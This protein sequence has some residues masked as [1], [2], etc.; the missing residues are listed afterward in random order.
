MKSQI[1]IDINILKNN[2]MLLGEN[3]EEYDF[4]II[5]MRNNCFGLGSF[6]VNTFAQNGF[7]YG[8]VTDLK[9]ALSVRKYNQELPLIV[10]SELW[11]D[12]IYD[13]INNNLVLMIGSLTYLKSLVLKNLKDDLAIHLLVDNGANWKGFANY[14]ELSEAISLINQN[15]HLVL[16]GIYTE[17]TTYGLDDEDYYHQMHNFL[18]TI[19]PIDTRELLIYA[20]EP[21][22]YHPKMAKINGIKLDLAV[23][24]L[25]QSFNDYN[26]RRVKKIAK[27]YP[28]E[29]FSDLDIQLKLSFAITAPVNGLKEVAAGTLIGR[30]YRAG[31]DTKI[32]SI[33][34]GH[35]DGVT[36]ALKVVVINDKICDCLTDSLEEM[37]VKVDDS[38]AVGDKVY[39]ISDFNNISSVLLNLKTNRYYLMSLLN[40]N[41][42]RVYY[43]DD[44]AEEINY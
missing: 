15:K 33:A 20:N 12:E 14:R 32:A 22:M 24:G 6:L 1:E 38:I 28:G 2:I 26:W 11:E 35:K 44:Q 34:I 21:L 17:F 5:D 40:N 19:E 30:N 9:E 43:Q 23:F 10:S 25:P 7:T 31:E 42:P 13:A 3:N 29:E 36:K 8:L 37:V 27:L 41:L 18:N 39:L 16:T 4:K